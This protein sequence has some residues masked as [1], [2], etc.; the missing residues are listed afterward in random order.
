MV[1]PYS[2]Q[3]VPYAA[4]RTSLLRFAAVSEIRH[5][6]IRFETVTDVVLANDP[7]KLLLD[8]ASP[9]SHGE[10]GGWKSYPDD[11]DKAPL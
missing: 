11:E 6:F 9:Q 3:S 4:T 2:P 7:G 8:L 10:D 5:S 1:H